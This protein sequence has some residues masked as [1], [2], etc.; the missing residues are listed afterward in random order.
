MIE[1]LVVLLIGGVLAAVAAPAW[2]GFINR[3][4]LNTAQSN[5]YLA[6][7]S[8]QS[9]AKKDKLNYQVAFRTLANKAQFSVSRQLV[10]AT[11]TTADWNNLS[12]QNLD[13]SIG[14]D[15]SYMTFTQLSVI[16]NPPIRRVVFD[17]KGNVVG[18]IGGLGRVTVTNQLGGGSKACVFVSTLLGVARMTK[19]SGCTIP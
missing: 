16:P 17:H 8:A 5:L 18:G 4:R 1:T 3:Q 10:N 15:N 7:R 14:Y 19:D 13:P 2:L 9:S 12:W 6:I 11:A